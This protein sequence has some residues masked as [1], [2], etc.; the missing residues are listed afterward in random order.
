MFTYAIQSRNA[1]RT[2]LTEMSLDTHKIGLL[3]KERDKNA[4]ELATK[5]RRSVT[6]ARQV[7]NGYLPSKSGDAEFV[8][9]TLAAFLGVKPK[10]ILISERRKTA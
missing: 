9:S 8:V 4:F 2:M 6:Y 3:M 5:L 1:C 10:D 7:M